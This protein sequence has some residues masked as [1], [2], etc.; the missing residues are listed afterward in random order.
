MSSVYSDHTKNLVNAF[1]RGLESLDGLQK[2]KEGTE[3]GI[4]KQKNGKLLTT[5]KP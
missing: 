1:W 2:G 5:I 3:R 4:I